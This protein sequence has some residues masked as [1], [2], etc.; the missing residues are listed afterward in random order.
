MLLNSG[1][2]L[3]LPKSILSLSLSFIFLAIV[4]LYQQ[5]TLCKYSKYLSRNKL[6]FIMSTHVLDKQIDKILR[7]KGFPDGMAHPAC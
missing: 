7:D 1:S 3:D 6:F 4:F 2:I 5:E